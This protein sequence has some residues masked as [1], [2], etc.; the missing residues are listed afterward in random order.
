MIPLHPNKPKRDG[1]SIAPQYAVLAQ[2]C[3]EIYPSFFDLENRLEVASQRV[4]HQQL[5]KG[6][7]YRIRI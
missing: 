6:S 4:H 3:A 7:T 2:P 5:R 1:A